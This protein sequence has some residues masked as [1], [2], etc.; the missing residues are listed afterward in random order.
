MYETIYHRP[1]SVDEA[2]A[3]FGKGSEFEISRRRPYADPRDETAAGL[4][5]P[6]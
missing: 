2:V 1:S 4:R 3:L 5:H 6:T